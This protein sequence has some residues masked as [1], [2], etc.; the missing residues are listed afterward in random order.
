SE[1]A[2]GE[3][4]QALEARLELQRCA[5]ALC[6]EIRKRIAE[7]DLVAQALLRPDEQRAPGKRLALPPGL[8]EQLPARAQAMLV[9]GPG[10]VQPA[11]L[12]APA[13]QLIKAEVAAR[14]AVPGREGDGRA[15][16]RL[17]ALEPAR[18]GIRIAEGAEQIGVLGPGRRGPLARVGS[19]VRLA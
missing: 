7:H 18:E 11:F 5:H 8:R 6:N 14:A 19:P 12:Q 17:A 2:K 13:H 3:R 1:A 10:A 16:Q 9:P 15:Q 4:E